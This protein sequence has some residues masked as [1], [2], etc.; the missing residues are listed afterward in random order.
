M[1]LPLV[2]MPLETLTHIAARLDTRGFDALRG[3]SRAFRELLDPYDYS[4]HSN[5]VATLAAKLAHSGGWAALKRRIA[6]APAAVPVSLADAASCCS[7]C[8]AHDVGLPLDDVRAKYAPHAWGALVR[9]FML[10]CAS[11]D[12]ASMNR[13][14][15]FL[16]HFTTEQLSAALCL[17]WGLA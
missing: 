5:P 13:V 11:Y 15:S 12:A 10:V 1:P 8:V 2:A 17:L 3:T 14:S 7:V 16:A 9:T 4:V 6:N